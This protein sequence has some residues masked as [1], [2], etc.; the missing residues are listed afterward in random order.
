MNNYGQRNLTLS[1]GEGAV[2][3]DTQGRAYLDCIAG[4]AV[5]GLGHCPPDITRAIQLQT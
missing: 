5:C 1:R 3:W 4:I 2:L